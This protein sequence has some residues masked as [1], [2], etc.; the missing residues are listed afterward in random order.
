VRS[1]DALRR[2]AADWARR[3]ADLIWA[4]WS[5]GRSQVPNRRA[6]RPAVLHRRAALAA[7]ERPP[8]VDAAAR[9]GAAGGRGGVG[10]ASVGGQRS[11]RRSAPS[12]RMRT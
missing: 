11:P 7:R 1:A 6:D 8:A 5:L 4:P 3:V 10:R 12:G 2:L 9:A